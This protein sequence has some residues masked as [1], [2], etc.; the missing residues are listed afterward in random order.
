MT[1]ESRGGNG[2]GEGQDEERKRQEEIQGQG[3][4]VLSPCQLQLT[5]TE[6]LTG[7]E[8]AKKDGWEKTQRG[9]P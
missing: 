4:R 7:A 6:M 5:E 9:E 8:R 2:R 3:G 1:E